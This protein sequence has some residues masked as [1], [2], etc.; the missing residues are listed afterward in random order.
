M[1]DPSACQLANTRVT[2]VICLY[3]EGV[4]NQT[5]FGAI[6]PVEGSFAAYGGSYAPDYDS[7]MYNYMIVLYVYVYGLSTILLI[8]VRSLKLCNQWVNI[9]YMYMYKLNV[10]LYHV[11]TRG[12]PRH[13]QCRGSEVPR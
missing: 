10:C 6:A 11:H 2:V 7:I 1:L 5:S 9:M 4:N 8:I 12:C 13:C 3:V